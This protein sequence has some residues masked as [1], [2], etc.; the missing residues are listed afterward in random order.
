[1][2]PMKMPSLSRGP[3][4]IILL[5]ALQFRNSLLEAG[6]PLGSFKTLL[7][8]G[9]FAPRSCLASGLVVH[10]DRSFLFNANFFVSHCVGY[11]L[12]ILNIPL[13]DSYFSGNYR[14]LHHADPFFRYRHTDFAFLTNASG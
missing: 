2:K 5:F 8:C 14:L 10:I 12:I 1:M 13:M 3:L 7:G 11:L 6:I 9:F 4:L